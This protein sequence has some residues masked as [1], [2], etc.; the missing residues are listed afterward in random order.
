LVGGGVEW[1]VLSGYLRK[2]GPRTLR[3]FPGR[4]LNIHPSLLPRHGGPGMYGRRVHDA[5]LAGG[6]ARTGASVHLVDDLYDHGLVIA[7]AELPVSPNETAESL[8]RRVMAAEPVLF[9]E[10]LKR[11]AEGAL[12]IPVISDNTS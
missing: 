3:A 5:V 1:V 12:T 11:I 9:L 8:E 4:I 7:R 6:D 10:T 2:L